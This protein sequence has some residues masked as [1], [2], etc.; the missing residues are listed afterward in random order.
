MS[1]ESDLYTLLKDFVSNRVYPDIAPLAVVHPYIT[2]QGVG[3]RSLRFMDNTAADKRNTRV[4]I[5]AWATT[6]A[7]ANALARQV[8]D[9]MCATALFTASPLGEPVSDYDTET[10][11]YGAMQDFS[12]F[13]AR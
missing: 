4:Q 6:R 5:N 8:E 2:W 7:A 13:S 1:M 9:A 10:K 11:T 3:G 12:I